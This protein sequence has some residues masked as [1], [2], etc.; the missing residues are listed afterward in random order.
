M[1]LNEPGRQKLGILGEEESCQQA[2]HAQLY[3]DLLQA[4][5]EGT[6]DCP[7]LPPGETL[8]SVSAIPSGSSSVGVM[9]SDLISARACHLKH[10]HATK[11]GDY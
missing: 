7:G 4:Q 9:I 6:F 5:T 3:S 11:S 8:I 10:C 1:K 2:K